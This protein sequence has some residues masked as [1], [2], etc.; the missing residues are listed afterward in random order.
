MS[1]VPERYEIK[2]HHHRQEY[3]WDCGIS[4]VL[5]VLPKDKREF[6]INNFQV[7]CKEEGFCKSTWTIDLCYLLKRFSVD[8]VFYTTTIGIHP[9]HKRHNFYAKIIHKVLS[10]II[11]LITI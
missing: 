4:C 2:L 5:M 8:F 6:F 3:N 1:K 11:T 7:I 9:H 10:I